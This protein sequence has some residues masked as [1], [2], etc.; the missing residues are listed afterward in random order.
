VPLYLHFRPHG[1]CGIVEEA[2]VAQGKVLSRVARVTL[3]HKC[4]LTTAVQTNSV[5]NTHTPLVGADLP[6]ASQQKAS[7]QPRRVSCLRRQCSEWVL[8]TMRCLNSVV[9]VNLG[10]AG[11]NLQH[12]HQ[13]QA[14]LTRRSSRLQGRTQQL[15]SYAGQ[16]LK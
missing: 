7:L 5:R 1:L 8:L 11:P 10:S 6:R 3:S 9:K 4:S 13:V 15:M 2:P 16:Y 14:C 12:D